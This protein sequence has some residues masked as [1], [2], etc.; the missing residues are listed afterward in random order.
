M[1]AKAIELACSHL[2]KSRTL[3][4]TI[5]E[6]GSPSPANLKGTQKSRLAKRR[7]SPIETSDPNSIIQRQLV[8]AHFCRSTSSAKACISTPP[9][10]SATSSTSSVV[11]GPSSRNASY[12]GDASTTGGYNAG[13]NADPAADEH[14]QA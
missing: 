5:S 6:A 11:C 1:R 14:E 4:R 8:H 12:N 7:H 9:A 13:N 10:A 2:S 3:C